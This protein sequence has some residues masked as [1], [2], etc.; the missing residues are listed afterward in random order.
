MCYNFSVFKNRDE[1]EP[2]DATIRFEDGKLVEMTYSYTTIDGDS[3]L[4]MTIQSSVRFSDYGTT[5][6]PN[7]LN[8]I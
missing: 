2:T 6:I 4:E 8:F 5:V 1:P 3:Q 7:T